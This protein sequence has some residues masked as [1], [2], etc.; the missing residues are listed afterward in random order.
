MRRRAFILPL[1]RWL[2]QNL[3]TPAVVCGRHFVELGMGI[4]AKGVHMSN[5]DL[6]PCAVPLPQFGTQQ[7]PLRRYAC[8]MQSL[9]FEHCEQAMACVH[10]FRSPASSP[11]PHPHLGLSSAAPLDPMS[12]PAPTGLLDTPLCLHR[13]VTSRCQSMRRVAEKGLPRNH[14]LHLAAA[15]TRFVSVTTQQLPHGMQ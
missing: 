1:L 15:A 2:R 4:A 10:D 14:P 11:S 5:L 13:M 6:T 3:H 8:Q 7:L 12:R 9:Y